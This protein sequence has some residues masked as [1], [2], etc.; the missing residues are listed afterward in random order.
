MGRWVDR[1]IGG[2]LDQRWLGLAAFQL[3]AKVS[4]A[5][6]AHLQWPRD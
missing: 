1:W 3:W 2:S 5:L 6:F 4:Q